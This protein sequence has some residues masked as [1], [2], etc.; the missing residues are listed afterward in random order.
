M[1]GLF[2]SLASSNSTV[3]LPT[4]NANLPCLTSIM[5]HAVARKGLPK[6]IGT[7]LSSSISITTKSVGM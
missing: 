5:A 4:L 7:W 2:I 6:R 1:E 3:S